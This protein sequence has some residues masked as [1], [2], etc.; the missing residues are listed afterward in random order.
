VTIV[1]IT[2]FMH[3]AIEGSRVIVMEAGE[4]VMQ[5]PPREIFSR[6]EELRALQLDVP[7]TTDL[8]YR[9]H[10]R[11]SDFPGDLLTIPETVGTILQFAQHKEA[12]A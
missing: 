10:Q 9:L 2:H 7:Q 11:R 1:A 3:E 12:T 8:A 6:V 4:I 5:G